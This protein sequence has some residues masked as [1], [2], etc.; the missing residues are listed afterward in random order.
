MALAL[1]LALFPAGG[2]AMFV[3]DSY[4]YLAANAPDALQ[5]D[6]TVAYVASD[7]ALL[8]PFWCTERDL[9]SV[10]AMVF[11][12]VVE[13][14]SEQ[15]PVPLL[16]DSW[17]NDGKKW[18]FQL[19]SGIQFHNGYELV[20]GDVVAS[21]ENFLA[22]GETNPYYARLSLV[23]SMTAVDA[24]T[25]EVIGR[26]EGMITL[27]AM[28][29]PVV[30]R[31]SMGDAIPRG[32]GPYWYINYNTNISIR[33]E[34]NPLWWK[35]QPEISSIVF[36]RY[37]TTGDAIEALTTGR[38]DCLSTRSSK[39]AFT[40]KL[41]NIIATDYPTIT[42]EM[43]IPNLSDS[44]PLSDVRVRKAV[45]YA[46]DRST[47]ASNAYLDMALQTEVPILPDTWL[48]ESQSAVYYYSP[49]RAL[50]LLNEVGW[51]D[52]TGDAYLNQL[53][54]GML[55]DLSI[56]IVTYNEPT[57]TIRQNAIEQIARNL[58]AVGI[59]TTV[60]TLSQSEV[61][62]C[63]RNGNFDLA[64]IGVNLSEVP[65]M[66]PLFADG[67]AVNYSGSHTNE[68]DQILA[69]TLT[70]ATEEELKQAYSDLQMYIVDKL[71]IM[72]LLFRTGTVLSTRSMAGLSGTRQNDA[73]NGIEFVSLEE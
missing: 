39:A 20:A 48:Y 51:E 70:A 71:P 17:T 53:E 63:I 56:T 10:N 11:E 8:N 69:R 24:Y 7:G 62:S 27:Y 38:V 60:Y 34:R 33:L 42:Y 64:L 41:S 52:L 4:E 59:H 1:C 12:S 9:I 47:L 13:L 36:L 32:T 29:F 54:D 55:K 5:A 35:T 30:E 18:T 3:E 22:A 68:M 31:T 28:T 6:L 46:I 26:Y 23:E 45:M 43:L 44:S 25:L 19:R 21:Y 58:E 50:Q 16:A 40:R 66:T 49:E 61:G 2:L 65:L 72:G 57:S 67:G 15:K 73:F 37:Y 14:D